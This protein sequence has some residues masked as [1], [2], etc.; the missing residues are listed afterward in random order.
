MKLQLDT[1]PPPEAPRPRTW[2]DGFGRTSLRC[3]QV[4]IVLALATVVVLGAIQLKLVVIPVIIALILAAAV[5]PVTRLMIRHRVPAALATVIAMVLGVGILLAVIALVSL[6]V[7]NQ[8]KTLV[9]SASDGVDQMQQFVQSGGLPV[10][11]AQIDKARDTAVTYLTSSSFGN[12]ALAGLSAVGSIAAGLFLVIVVLFFFL[13]DGPMIWS[14]LIRPLPVEQRVRAARIGLRSIGVLGAYVRGTAG[15]AL[16][17]TVF[18]GAGL[19]ILGV[20]LAIPLAVIV[21]VTAFI[22]I[23]GATAAGI[24]AALV[25]L[26]TNGPVVAVIVVAIVIVVN[27]LEGNLLQPLIMGRSLSLH[28]LVILLALT[29]GTIVGGIIGA[30]LA[31]PLTSVAWT[32][33]KSWRNDPAEVAETA[34]QESRR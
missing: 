26:V 19:L 22:P 10:D 13:K 34:I 28:P 7:A 17:D 21:F 9:Q 4:L 14:F 24:I 3:L 2:T 23:V 15:V 11:S 18:I 6:A 8:W 32:A 29:A 25:A 20:P 12:S 31:V 1:A 33:I 27:Q 16:V 5:S 30:V